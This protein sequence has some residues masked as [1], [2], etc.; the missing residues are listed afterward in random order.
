[1]ILGLPWLRWANPVIDWAAQAIRF[2]GQSAGGTGIF[3][4]F[5]FQKDLRKSQSV[6]STVNDK[7]NRS[8]KG[9]RQSLD[10]EMVDNEEFN[11]ICQAES[12]QAFVMEYTDLRRDPQGAAF[13]KNV[14]IIKLPSQ[15][16]EFKNVF[17][18]NEADVLSEHGPYNHAIEIEESKE[19]P[20]GPVYNMSITE[21]N[22]LK[23]YVNE[24]LTKGFI[25]PS[26]FPAGAPVIFIKKKNGG[27]R[28]CVNY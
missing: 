5:R 16:A 20:F 23:E 28:F 3:F 1:M 15:Y 7:E 25:R 4:P 19:P 6:V 27:L 18:Q 10:I 9:Q 24:M 13:H 14:K 21:L 11:K 2:P 17:D 22:A 12:T 26:K 8:Y